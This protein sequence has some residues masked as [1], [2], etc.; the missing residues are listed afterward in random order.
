MVMQ[1]TGDNGDYTTWHQEPMHAE[2]TPICPVIKMNHHASVE[3]Y[4]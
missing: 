2:Q 4:C 1:R 3:E